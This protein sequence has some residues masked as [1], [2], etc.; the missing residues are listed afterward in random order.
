MKRVNWVPAP[1]YFNLNAACAV[2]TQAYCTCPYLVGSALKRRDFRDV[3][4]RLILQDE[5]FDARFPGA[6]GRPD[7]HA[8]WALTCSSIAVWLQMQSGLPIDFQI[9]RMTQANE[10]YGLEARHPIGIFVTIP[11]PPSYTYRT[12][13]PCLQ[14]LNLGSSDPSSSSG[15]DPDA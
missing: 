7:L 13:G 10:E 9:Q 6:G 5:E 4:I 11:N 2:I 1:Q 14:P 12:D 3:D 15:S 8:L